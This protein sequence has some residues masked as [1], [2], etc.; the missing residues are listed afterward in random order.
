M[1]TQTKPMKTWNN[2]TSEKYQ[3]DTNDQYAPVY[4]EED[5]SEGSNVETKER[6]NTII[7]HIRENS[8]KV[9]DRLGMKFGEN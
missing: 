9:A 8:G 4:R 5:I 3:N 1:A 7:L 6:E 2:Q